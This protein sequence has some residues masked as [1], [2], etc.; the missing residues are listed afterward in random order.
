MVIPKILSSIFLLIIS[1]DFPYHFLNEDQLKGK[2]NVVL[3]PLQLSVVHVY[4]TLSYEF[5]L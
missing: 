5:L 1:G 4:A 2:Y 3:L